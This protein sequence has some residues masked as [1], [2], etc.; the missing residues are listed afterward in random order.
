MGGFS[1]AILLRRRALCAGCASPKFDPGRK[2]KVGPV[3]MIVATYRVIN[4]FEMLLVEP[5]EC[6]QSA[7]Q[8]REAP[9]QNVG[10]ANQ[11]LPSVLGSRRGG[12]IREMEGEE[13]DVVL[14][15]PAGGEAGPSRQ[16]VK[17]CIDELSYR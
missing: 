11:P 5:N 6:S 2:A 4:R 9:L 12:R 8:T 14:R 15:F 1:W 16:L 10:A 17:K 3:A 7:V 13:R